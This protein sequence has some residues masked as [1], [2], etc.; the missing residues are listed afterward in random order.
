MVLQGRQGGGRRRWGSANVTTAK[1]I[2]ANRRVVN[3]CKGPAGQAA[4]LIIYRTGD[5]TQAVSVTLLA[6]GLAVRAS[7]GNLQ[8]GLFGGMVVSFADGQDFAQVIM[9]ARTDHF[10][11]DDQ[12]CCCDLSGAT[13]GVLGG[14]VAVDLTVHDTDP[15]GDE[16]IWAG[17][18]NNTIVASVGDNLLN[19]QSRFDMV[20]YSGVETGKKSAGLTGDVNSFAFCGKRASVDQ[21]RNVGVIPMAIWHDS[22]GIPKVREV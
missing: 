15:V 5:A 3:D 11:T 14:N 13:G 20:D 2:Q 22:F 21:V 1:N 19:G 9:F 7:C 16:M 17:A 8:G 4:S 10:Q 18:G 6:I 12:G